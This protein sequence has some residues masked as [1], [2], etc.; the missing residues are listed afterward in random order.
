MNSTTDLMHSAHALRVR[1]H[2]QCGET[3]SRPGRAA[4][5]GEFPHYRN[6]FRCGISGEW[7]VQYHHYHALQCRRPVAHQCAEAAHLAAFAHA[8]VELGFC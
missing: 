5:A 6:F 3:D 7:C 4:F 8:G 1:L 2:G